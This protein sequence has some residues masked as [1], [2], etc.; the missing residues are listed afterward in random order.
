MSIPGCAYLQV[1]SQVEPHL[2]GTREALQAHGTE[3]DHWEVYLASRAA[4]WR[5]TVRG[6]HARKDVLHAQQ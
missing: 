3:P 5:G 2:D 4:A 1:P 6:P